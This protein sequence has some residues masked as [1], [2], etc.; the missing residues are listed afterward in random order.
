MKT[1]FTG[2]FSFLIAFSQL[3]AADRIWIGAGANDN[4]STAANWGGTAPVNNDQ[5][6]F[7]G[8]AR[9]QNFNDL[10]NLTA[11]GLTF[12]ANGFSLSGNALA[13]NPSGSGMIT[14]FSGTNTVALDLNILAVNKN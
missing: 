10:P 12:S 14:N 4:W 3:H 9:Q 13:L 5:L 8:A 1:L 6:I 11:R 7:S 2:A